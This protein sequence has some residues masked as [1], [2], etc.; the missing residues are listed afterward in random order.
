MSH[1]AEE[2]ECV[3]DATGLARSVEKE[4]MKK[5]ISASSHVSH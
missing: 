4:K 5:E 3:T 1:D 2:W